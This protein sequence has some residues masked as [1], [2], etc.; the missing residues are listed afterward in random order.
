MIFGNKSGIKPFHVDIRKGHKK[1]EPRVSI[2]PWKTV[3]VNREY[4]GDWFNIADIDG[5][6]DVGDIVCQSALFEHI[7]RRYFCY[8]LLRAKTRRINTLE[9]GRPEG[10]RCEGLDKTIR[11]HDIDNDWNNDGRDKIAFGHDHLILDGCGN[12]VAD[13][14]IPDDRRPW[15]VGIG[16]CT[17]SGT[18][19][20][21]L[22]VYCLP[23]RI[24]GQDEWKFDREKRDQWIYIYT[25]PD[26]PKEKK[27]KS[28]GLGC[29]FTFY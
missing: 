12:I 24:E 18:K 6:G 21:V 22:P 4:G 10:R 20:I 5:D 14:A 2:E 25:N 1:T 9:L 29:N 23:E 28:G 17:G 3:Q 11:A 27:R 26:L 19:D 13:L 8:L 7:C 16:D 15:I